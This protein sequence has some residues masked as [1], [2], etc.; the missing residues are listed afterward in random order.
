MV[1]IFEVN[2]KECARLLLEYP[3]WCVPGTF[4]P[5]SGAPPTEEDPNVKNWQLE[6]VVV[7]VSSV[8]GSSMAYSYPLDGPWLVV[9]P[10]RVTPKINLLHCA[11]HRA[12]QTLTLNRRSSGWQV[13]QEAV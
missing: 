1:D 12:L 8:S 7:E 10:S 3:K 6:S 11:D 2:R 9:P 4:K 13:Y 5:G